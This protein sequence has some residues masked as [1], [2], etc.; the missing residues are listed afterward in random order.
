MEEKKKKRKKKPP[1][2][3]PVGIQSKCSM[4]KGGIYYVRPKR[5]PILTNGQ[6]VIRATWAGQPH[7]TPVS[8]QLPFG[9]LWHPTRVKDSPGEKGR[10]TN[11]DKSHFFFF[12]RQRGRKSGEP[13]LPVHQAGSA[14]KGPRGPAVGLCGSWTLP[15]ANA[16]SSWQT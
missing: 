6:N 14:V 12:L 2:F 5:K 11:I 9:A 10:V 15:S 1:G 4:S 16:T 8:Q 13:E 7:L 3:L